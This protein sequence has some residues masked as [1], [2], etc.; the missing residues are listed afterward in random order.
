MRT[1][2]GEIFIHIFL[3]IGSIHN[4]LRL[5]V[6]HNEK[7]RC[8]HDAVLCGKIRVTL[9]VDHLILL[10]GEHDEVVG[11]VLHLRHP[12]GDEVIVQFGQVLVVNR[13]MPSSSILSAAAAAFGSSFPAACSAS[14]SAAPYDFIFCSGDLE[15]MIS[16]T[17]LFLYSWRFPSFQFLT[18]R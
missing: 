1:D 11:G 14:F 15:W 12:V 4:L 3:D 7:S 17:V 18:G 2:L 6:L 16:Y 8:L 10:L 5:A 9:C 13:Y